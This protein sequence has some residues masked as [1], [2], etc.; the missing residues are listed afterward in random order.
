MRSQ[1]KHFITPHPI[2]NLHVPPNV[3]P[4]AKHCFYSE[5]IEKNKD[6]KRKKS[7]NLINIFL[8]MLVYWSQDH[9]VLS[10]YSQRT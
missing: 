7:Q 3:P 6:K 4:N 1:P 8:T 5:N 10:C 2:V 9:R